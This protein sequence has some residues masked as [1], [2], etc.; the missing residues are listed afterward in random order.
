VWA[1]IRVLAGE[2]LGAW[3]Q[4][5]LERKIFHLR[6]A[7]RDEAAPGLR[8]ERVY[9]MLTNL[10]NAMSAVGRPVEAIH[11]WDQALRRLPRFSMAR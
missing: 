9:Q 3:E 2:D 8:P 11:Y 4:P 5:E 1:R 7:L 6:M 10:G